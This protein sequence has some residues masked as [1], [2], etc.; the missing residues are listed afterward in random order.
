MAEPTQTRNSQITIDAAIKLF[1]RHLTSEWKRQK[2]PYRL[3]ACFDEAN[4]ASEEDTSRIFVDTALK[5]WVSYFRVGTS[6]HYLG[7]SQDQQT[8]SDFQKLPS[9]D[10]RAVALRL[11][12]TQVH[13]TVQSVIEKTEQVLS[14]HH[15]KLPA[16]LLCSI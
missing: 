15:R 5:A 8:L 16:E 1:E 3:I 11:A 10:R 7:K 4:S 6:E 9:E 14:K 13:P 12:E 2:M